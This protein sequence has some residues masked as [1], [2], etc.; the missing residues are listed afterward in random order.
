MPI[1]DFTYQRGYG[2]LNSERRP[3]L[4]SIDGWY[5]YTKDSLPVIVPDQWL[6][7][8][9]AVDKYKKLPSGIEAVQMTTGV[10]V[11]VP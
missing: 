2:M 4:V 11:T 9:G 3:P 5:F 8:A 7:E 6:T 10:K 1:G